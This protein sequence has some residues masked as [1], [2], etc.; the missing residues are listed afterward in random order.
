MNSTN[1]YKEVDDSVA[2]YLQNKSDKKEKKT[3]TKAVFAEPSPAYIFA[4]FCSFLLPGL[5]Q[6]LLDRKTGAASLF[7]GALIYWF[8]IL[9]FSFDASS[10][11]VM[12]FVVLLSI[13]PN[14]IAAY[15]AAN[16][17]KNS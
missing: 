10:L 11:F 6:L 8:M 5:G 14:V 16:G 2:N 9:R 4:G 7:I 12:A 1:N 15:L 17:H 3:E 13:I